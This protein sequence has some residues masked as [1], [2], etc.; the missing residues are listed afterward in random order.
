LAPDLQHPKRPNDEFD[1]DEPVVTSDN[2]V[3]LAQF[4][5]IIKALNDLLE[6]GRLVCFISLSNT[7]VLLS[8]VWMLIIRSIVPACTRIHHR[9]LL[10][11]M[12]CK[13][14]QY[15]KEWISNNML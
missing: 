1:D 3:K 11:S 4:R 2:L 8:L 10:L 15:P 14:S 7:S 13:R 9:V 12:I 6:T 5:E